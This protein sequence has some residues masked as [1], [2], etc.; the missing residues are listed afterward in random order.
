MRFLRINLR[1]VIVLIVAALLIRAGAT[2]LFSGEFSVTRGMP[3]VRFPLELAGP[4]ARLIGL[5][6]IVIAVAGVISVVRKGRPAT[7]QDESS[8]EDLP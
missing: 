3:A 7:D 8:N 6:L 4:S 5:A 1:G 2:A